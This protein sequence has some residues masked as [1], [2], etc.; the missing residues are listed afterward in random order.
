MWEWLGANIAIVLAV[1]AAVW[2][3]LRWGLVKIAAKTENTWDDKLAEMVNA[4]GPE[5]AQEY[6]KSFIEKKTAKAE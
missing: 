4:I 3:L 1:V 5:Q 6:V 2:M